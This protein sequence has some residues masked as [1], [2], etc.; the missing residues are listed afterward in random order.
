MSSKIFQSTYLIEFGSSSKG[1]DKFDLYV[2]PSSLFDR[3]GISYQPTSDFLEE[4]SKKPKD[5]KY[6][7]KSSLFGFG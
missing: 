1:K 4:Y 2:R 5:D 6:K 7:A 3:C